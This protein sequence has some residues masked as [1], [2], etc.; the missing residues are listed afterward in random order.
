MVKR[1]LL[2]LVVA[3]AACATSSTGRK[4]LLLLPEDQ[5]SQLGA[6]AF[7]QMKAEE[8][9]SQAS[10]SNQYVRCLAD[11]LLE[12][13]GLTR[14]QQWEVVVFQSDQI[15]AFALP[16]GKIGVYS[17][18]VEFADT[19]EQL[20][21]VMGHEIGH[22]IEQHGNERVSQQTA[23][24]G[25]TALLAA[26]TNVGQS[27]TGQMVMAGL[28]LGYQ[29][30]IALPHSRTQE[31]ESDVIGTRLMAR[32][33]F[34]PAGAPQLWDKM[35]TL[36]NAGPEFLSTHP[37]PRKRAAYLRKMQAEVQPVYSAARAAGKRPNCRKP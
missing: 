35:A 18:M 8:P 5:M 11:A 9:V 7:V 28:G 13:G 22:V 20:A 33:G 31:E 34:D 14:D 29:F 2:T 6:E 19:P 23:A 26:V 36:G 3:A 37:D 10:A 15:N 4:Q 21:A 24:Q 32:A 1:A 30:G 27:E 25:I 17:G 12:A 16:G